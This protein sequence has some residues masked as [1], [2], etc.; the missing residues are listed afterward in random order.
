MAKWVHSDVLDGGLNAIR[1]GAARM[2]LIKAYAAGDSYAT[3]AGNA[4]C[5]I[6]M[7]PG[8]FT[9][10]GAPG[11]PRVCTVAAKSGTASAGSGPAPDLHIAFTDGS[12]KVLWVTDETSDQ[13]VTGG[14]TIGFPSITYTAN[15]PI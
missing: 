9:L 7:A 6:T 12:A 14:N 13:V 11:N 5:T 10:S 2:L 8:D 1:G 3:V 4:I 15:Q